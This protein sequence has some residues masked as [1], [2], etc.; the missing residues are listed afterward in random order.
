VSKVFCKR[1][2]ELGWLWVLKKKCSSEI[3]LFFMTGHL[4]AGWRLDRSRSCHHIRSLGRHHRAVPWYCRAGHLPGCRPPRLHL[5]YPRRQRHRRGALRC[6]SW[7][8]E[9]SS[10]KIEH[11]CYHNL[12]VSQKVLLRFA[13]VGHFFT[14]RLLVNFLL[15]EQKQ[16]FISRKLCTVIMDYCFMKILQ[17]K[18]QTQAD[19]FKMLIMP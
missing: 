4:C 17:Y 9:G 5:P 1:C 10:G 11:F 3:A 13:N 18:T 14:F 19:L 6:R 7:C 2:L 12:S 16:D 15:Q 8:A